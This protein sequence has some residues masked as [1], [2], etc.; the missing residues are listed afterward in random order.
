MTQPLHYS[1]HDAYRLFKAMEQ[2]RDQAVAELEQ[3]KARLAQVEAQMEART[4]PE[5][6]PC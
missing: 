6:Q 1:S 2:E 5:V 3:V 4:E